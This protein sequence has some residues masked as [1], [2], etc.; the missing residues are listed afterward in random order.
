MEKAVQDAPEGRLD[1]LIFDLVEWVGKQ[2]R[3]YAQVMEAWR[4]SCP[5][6][7]VWEEAVDRGYLVRCRDG[8]GNVSIQVTTAG[9]AFLEIS[10]SSC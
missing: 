1:S 3:S 5:R 9:N 6:L 10:R 4:T 7:T 2:P 8:D